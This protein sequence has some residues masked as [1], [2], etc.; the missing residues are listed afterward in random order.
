MLLWALIGIVLIAVV[1]ALIAAS[2]G[3]APARRE[4]VY[5]PPPVMV[6]EPSQIEFRQ[7]DSWEEGAKTTVSKNF[8]KG[9]DPTGVAMDPGG[10]ATS[11]YDEDIEWLKKAQAFEPRVTAKVRLDV[12]EEE[13]VEKV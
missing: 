7:T 5:E 11:K 9:G 4:V 10:M 6:K 13:E 2:A 1:W 3:K 12:D 8:G